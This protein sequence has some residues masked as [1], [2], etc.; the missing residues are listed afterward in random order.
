V[1]QD[2]K[3]SL[4]DATIELDVNTFPTKTA[5]DGDFRYGLVFHR[6]GDN[7]YAFTISQPTKKWYLLKNSPTGPVVL[8]EGSEESIHNRGENDHLRVD[9]KGPD[10]F[11]SIN[12]RQVDQVTDSDYTEGQ[13]GFYVQ[14]IDSKQVHIHFDQLIIRDLALVYSCSVPAATVYVRSGPGQNYAQ[15]GLLTSGDTV[16]AKGISSN[17]WIQIVREGS[18]D[19]GWVSYKFPG[20]ELSCTPSID[21][22]PIVSP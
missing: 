9:A 6:S 13:I 12:G 18:N 21:V 14:S 5:P 15:I 3:Y 22:F 11:L 7:Y 20:G 16:Q 8:R 1:P 19:P 4:G 2:K 10:F 17:Q